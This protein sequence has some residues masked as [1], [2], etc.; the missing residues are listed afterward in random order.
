VTLGAAL[1]VALV[2]TGWTVE[3]LPG[4]AP[5]L[6]RGTDTLE[7]FSVVQDLQDGKLTDQAWQ[8]RAAVLGIASLRLSVT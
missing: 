4:A 8:E 5:V 3:S 1:A 6:H 7:P 2:G